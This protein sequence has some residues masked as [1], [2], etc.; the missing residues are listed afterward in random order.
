[1][2]VSEQLSNAGQIASIFKEADNLKKLKHKNIV[3][4]DHALSLIH[5]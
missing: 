3:Q 2:D 4:L 1:M 5:I